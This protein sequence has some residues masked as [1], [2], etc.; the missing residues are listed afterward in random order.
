MR[1]IA[2]CL[3]ALI[4]AG[5]IAAAASAQTVV[6]EEATIPHSLASADGPGQA[7]INVHTRFTSIDSACFD[8]TFDAQNGLDPGESL[9][10]TPDTWLKDNPFARGPGFVNTTSTTQFSRELCVTNFPGAPPDPFLAELVDGKQRLAL[11]A[12]DGPVVVSS[13]TVTIVGTT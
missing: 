11:N 5:A 4:C 1:G 8:F 2:A 12:D 7:I 10:I 13:I 6:S 3:G 9:R